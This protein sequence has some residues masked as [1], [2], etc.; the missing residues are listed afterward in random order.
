MLR[1]ERDCESKNDQKMNVS[2]NMKKNIFLILLLPLCIHAMR[3]ETNANPDLQSRYVG[4]LAGPLNIHYAVGHHGDPKAQVIKR[5]VEYIMDAG[6]DLGGRGT[7]QEVEQAVEIVNQDRTALTRTLRGGIIA[8]QPLLTLEEF[9]AEWSGIEQQIEHEK[10][11]PD[12][13]ADIEIAQSA[14]LLRSLICQQK[15]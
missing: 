10:A 8:G 5:Y 11:T 4:F 12:P 13:I 15:G 1:T 3:F 7:A 2:E 14:H 9:Q 6:F